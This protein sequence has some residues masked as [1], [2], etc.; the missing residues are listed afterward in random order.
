MTILPAHMHMGLTVFFNFATK[1][2]NTDKI[3]GT[4]V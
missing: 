2:S 4:S 1:I 3:F